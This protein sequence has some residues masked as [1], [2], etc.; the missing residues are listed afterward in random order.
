MEH[1]LKEHIG[2]LVENKVTGEVYRLT[3]VGYHP[4]WGWDITVYAKSMDCSFDTSARHWVPRFRDNDWVKFC[5]AVPNDQ[6]Y[7]GRGEVSIKFMDGSKG[8]FKRSYVEKY[9]GKLIEGGGCSWCR[10]EECILT[11]HRAKND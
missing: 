5:D 4:T 9:L 7:D 3:H 11:K 8:Y 6:D 1:K 2:E 10:T